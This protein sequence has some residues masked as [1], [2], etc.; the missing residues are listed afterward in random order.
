MSDKEANAPKPDVEGHGQVGGQ[1]PGQ[2]P[3]ADTE[4]HM[5]M[6]DDTAPDEEREM[7]KSDEPDVEGHG[8]VPG[9]VP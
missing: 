9:Q 1:V 6:T 5:L 3:R 4:G 7:L 8:Q 2:V